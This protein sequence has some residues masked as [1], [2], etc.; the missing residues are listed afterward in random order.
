LPDHQ[1][2]QSLSRTVEADVEDNEDEDN[3]NEDNEDEDNKNEDNEDEDNKNEDNGDEDNE[4]VDNEDDILD[5]DEENS[6]NVPTLS[7]GPRP[8]SQPTSHDNSLVVQHK[9]KHHE[10]ATSSDCETDTG[11]VKAQKIN[12]NAGRP[13]AADYDDLAKDLILR[14]ATLYRCLLS[15]QDA[16]PDLAHEAEM[17]KMAWAQV[18]NETGFTPLALTPDIAKIVSDNLL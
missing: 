8:G 3:K 11:H 12:R 15:T 14:A 17:V 5:H 7:A 13:R 18:N 4:D 6:F 1:H 10:S 2:H 9:R 16:F